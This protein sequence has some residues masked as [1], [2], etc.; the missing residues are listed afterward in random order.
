MKLDSGGGSA[1]GGTVGNNEVWCG[2]KHLAEGIQEVLADGLGVRG[3]GLGVV[4]VKV[5]FGAAPPAVR[6]DDARDRV[7]G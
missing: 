1:A 6:A 7:A 2:K 4:V 5:G 3:W